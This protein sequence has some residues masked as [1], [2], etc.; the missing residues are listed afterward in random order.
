LTKRLI[1]AKNTGKNMRRIVFLLL[2]AFIYNNVKAE[3]EVSPEDS[4]RVVQILEKAS[5]ERGDENRMIY[6]GRQFLGVPYVAHTLENGEKEHLIVNVHGLD[7]TTFVETVTALSICD[8]RGERTFAGFCKWLEKLRYRD[9]RMT[10]YTSRLHYF[11]WWGEDNEK[12]GLVRCVDEGSVFAATQTVDVYYMTKFPNYYKHLKG[13]RE[14]VRRIGEYERETKGRK[15]RYIPKRMLNMRQSSALGVIEDG[16][17]ISMLTSKAGLDT[18]HIGIAFWK[19]GRLHLMHASSMYGKVVMD[20]TTFYDY[21]M[22]VRSHVG[23]RVY[24]A[25]FYN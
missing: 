21:E 5:G 22:K 25:T 2:V 17:I 16:D 18:Q 14:F 19:N 23:V 3:V 13:N 20:E 6:F 15:Y 12:L 1:F 7:C 8:A 11:T 4:L 10:D 24:R 9:G